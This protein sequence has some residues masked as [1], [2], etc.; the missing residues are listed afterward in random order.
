MSYFSIHQ[1]F[2]ELAVPGFSENFRKLFG[3]R[4]KQHNDI[5]V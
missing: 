2:G 4:Q 1:A 5:Y 3:K